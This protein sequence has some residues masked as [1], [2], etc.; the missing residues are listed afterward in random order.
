MKVLKDAIYSISPALNLKTLDK[1]KDRIVDMYKLY[2]EPEFDKDGKF[3]NKKP[4]KKL[5]NIDEDS[6]PGDMSKLE[7]F[8]ISIQEDQ[9]IIDDLRKEMELPEGTLETNLFI[10]TAIVCTKVDLIEHGDKEIKSILEKNLD[11]IQYTLRKYCLSY[12]S[13][14]LFTSS[15]SN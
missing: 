6:R 5:Q 12:G 8:D 7:E 13:T 15:N 1:L 10:P 9:E 14:L 2:E 3:I 4:K 11:F